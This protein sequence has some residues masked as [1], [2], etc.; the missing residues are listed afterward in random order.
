MWQKT[1]CYK[2]IQK[3]R[4]AVKDKNNVRFESIDNFLNQEISPVKKDHMECMRKVEFH[5]TCTLFQ[6]IH[7][8]WQN[9]G[10]R[11]KRENEHSDDDAKMTRLY[12]ISPL[13]PLKDLIFPKFFFEGLHGKSIFY[14]WSAIQGIYSQRK[15]WSVFLGYAYQV[16]RGHGKMRFG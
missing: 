6:K 8:K 11:Q 5:C 14:K 12:S 4:V 13:K 7:C 15:W 2:E 16:E 1:W 9:V 3:N 10:N